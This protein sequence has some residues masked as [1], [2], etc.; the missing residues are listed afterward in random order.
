MERK[1]VYGNLALE[2]SPRENLGSSAFRIERGQNA[3]EAEQ[4][5]DLLSYLGEY[6]FGLPIYNYQLQFAKKDGEFH[7][8]DKHRLE[9]MVVKAKR[10]IVDRKA[11]GLPTERETAERIALEK[12]DE[13]LTFAGED[14]NIFWA[15]PPGPREQGYGDYGFVFVGKIKHL[16]SDKQIDMTAIRVESP[17]LTDFNRA[18]SEVSGVDIN[19]GSAEEFIS[20]PLVLRGAEKR[21]S[22]ALSSFTIKD[23][24]LV[25]E[26]F[27]RNTLRVK[28]LID[29]FVKAK[30]AEEKVMLLNT[31]E[32]CI[33]ALEQGNDIFFSDQKL[34]TKEE[35][36]N[37]GALVASYGNKKAPEVQ[38]SCGSSGSETNNIFNNVST[39]A[40]LLKGKND[41]MKCVTCPFC[42][43][44]V[45][46]ELAEGKITCPKCKESANR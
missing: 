5:D 45:D 4:R 2:L 34:L 32:N 9:P 17:E 31:I 36:I 7:L 10:A 13:M 43:E 14:C 39:I 40:S 42:N 18:L 8:R 15:S 29:R 26:R 27:K 30:T 3:L 46:A 38:G 1:R 6:R 25:F 24:A 37:I 20:S 23:D 12:L 44:T 33:V 28:P 41:L 19:Y 35:D 11:Q 22:K 16:G 21:V